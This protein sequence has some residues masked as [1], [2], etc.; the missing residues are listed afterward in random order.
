[1]TTDELLARALEVLP[2]LVPNSVKAAA[3]QGGLGRGYADTHSDVDVLLCIDNSSDTTGIPVGA[4]EHKGIEWGFISL[5]FDQV[6]V[7]KWLDRQRFVYAY[8][9]K[10]LWDID[11]RLAHLCANAA[12]TDNEVTQRLT[13]H[14]K[15][16]ANRGITYKGLYRQ[17]WRGFYLSV[18]PDLWLER[19]DPLAAQ[20]RLNQGYTKLVECIFALNHSPTPSAKW[21]DH[22]VSKLPWAPAGFRDIQENFFYNAK[23]TRGSF[24]YRLDLLTGVLTNCV[25]YAT[26]NGWLSDDLSSSYRSSNFSDDTESGDQ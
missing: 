13:Y 11:G 23:P 3:F 20:M 12:L 22:L 19:G 1:M 2:E 5:N 10:I 4:L 16:L 6:V 21:V 14:V 18:R 17:K 7:Q 8:E 9:T 25:D 15:K 24:D 26:E